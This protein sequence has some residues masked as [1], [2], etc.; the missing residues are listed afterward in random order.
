MSSDRPLSVAERIAALQKN[1]AGN[2]STSTSGAGIKGEGVGGKKKVSA[3]AGDLSSKL[4]MN[5][6]LA[7][8][9]GGKRPSSSNNHVTDP[10]YS[11]QLVTTAKAKVDEAIVKEGYLQHP[12]RAMIPPGRRRRRGAF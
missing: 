5:A 4:D 11:A 2:A 7:G 6:L 12:P 8:G 3:L 10:S 9:A 1:A